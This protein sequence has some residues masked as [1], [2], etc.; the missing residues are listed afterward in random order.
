M[1]YVFSIVLFVNDASVTRISSTPPSATK[2]MAVAI[3]PGPARIGIAGGVM[4]IDSGVSMYTFSFLS[5]HSH[6]CS[7]SAVGS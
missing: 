2:L 1:E 7:M 3:V 5:G 4:A 6:V